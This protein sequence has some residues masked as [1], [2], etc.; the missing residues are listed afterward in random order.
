VPGAERERE[1]SE[2]A[3][4]IAGLLA[5]VPPAPKPTTITFRGISSPRD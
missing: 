4:A 2:L 5:R 3:D 1:F